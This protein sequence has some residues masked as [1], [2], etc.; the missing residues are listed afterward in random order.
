MTVKKVTHEVY[1]NGWWETRYVN[2][3]LVEDPYL[4][5]VL[6]EVTSLVGFNT[7]FDLNYRK[8]AALI[9][10]YEAD[11]KARNRIVIY[12]EE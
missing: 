7:P 11:F 9:Y 10:A 2:R 12:P 1:E 5:C 6:T 8:E 4:E 3:M